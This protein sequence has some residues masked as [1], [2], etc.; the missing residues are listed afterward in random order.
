VPTLYHPTVVRSASGNGEERAAQI[1]RIQERLDRL[2]R[3]AEQMTSEVSAVTHDVEKL[4]GSEP[5][6]SGPPPKRSN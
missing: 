5:P 6:A 3:F 2:R 4:S 1:E